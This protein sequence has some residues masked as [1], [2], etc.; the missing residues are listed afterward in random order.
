M[1]KFFEVKKPA[2]PTFRIARIDEGWLDLAELLECLTANAKVATVLG[3]IPASSFCFKV[4]KQ[5]HPTYRIG[6]ING[7]WMRRTW[8]GRRLSSSPAFHASHQPP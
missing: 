2:H 3:S 4:K 1:R 5:A 8:V 7:D 6:R